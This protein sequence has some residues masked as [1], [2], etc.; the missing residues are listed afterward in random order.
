MLDAQIMR[1]QTEQ[2]GHVFRGLVAQCCLA[3][4]L[5]QHGSSFTFKIMRKSWPTY[6]H[7]SIWKSPSFSSLNPGISLLFAIKELLRFELGE[8]EFP[9]GVG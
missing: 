8:A 2:N 1:S 4:W 6:L 7:F 3:I 9:Q 5:L